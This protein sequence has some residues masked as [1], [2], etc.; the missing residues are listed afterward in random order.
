MGEKSSTNIWWYIVLTFIIIIFVA[1]IQNYT[2]AQLYNP[3]INATLSDDDLAYILS[4]NGIDISDYNVT[5]SEL[6][7]DNALGFSND[8]GSQAKDTAIEFFY[9]RSTASQIGV[10]A[11]NIFSLPGFLVTLLR[12]P[13]NAIGWLISLLNWFWRLGIIMAGYYL[14]RG[15][16]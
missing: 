6:E 5:E 3:D 11:K 1:A 12:I 14:I 4:I 7:K 9:S 2:S 13:D 16:K 8:T 15:I 10:F